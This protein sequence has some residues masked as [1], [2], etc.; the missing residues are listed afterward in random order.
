MTPSIV[1]LGLSLVN[2]HEEVMLP[3]LREEDSKR[4]KEFATLPAAK[5]YFYQNHLPEQLR[6]NL[7]LLS[8]GEQ[9]AKGHSRHTSHLNVVDEVHQLLQE[10]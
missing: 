10:S 5:S 6:D 3:S 1:L 9:V 4:E 2:G 7:D 8:S